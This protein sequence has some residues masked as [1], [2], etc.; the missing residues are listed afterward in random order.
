MVQPEQ[1][2][3]IVERAL[4]G[5]RLKDSQLVGESR[6]LLVLAGGE[7]LTLHCYSSPAD[8]TTAA[9]ALRLLRAEIDLPLA[10]LRAA[11]E[12]GA[13]GVPCVITQE[14]RGE[15]LAKVLPRVPE[16]QQYV[17][18]QRLGDTAFRIH[19]IACKQYGTLAGGEGHRDERD[20]VLARLER[21]LTRCAKLGVLNKVTADAIRAWFTQAFRPTGRQPALV[22]GGLSPETILVRQTEGGWKLSGLL[23]WEY[24]RGWSPIWEHVTFFEIADRARFFSLRVGY[25]NAYDDLTKRAYEQVRDTAM[26]PYRMLLLLEHMHTAA[27]RSDMSAIER[28]RNSIVSILQLLTGSNQ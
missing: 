1:L 25:G 2:T 24:A 19:R 14:L 17:I 26:M 28:Q 8:A 3:M 10:Q 13:S 18:G 20:Y 27:A 15:T 21:D 4:P 11:D 6:Y 16:A 5:E 12:Q 23:G 7:R 22:H 9:T